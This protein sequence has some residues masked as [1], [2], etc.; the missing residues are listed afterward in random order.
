MRL[1]RFV[2]LVLA[3]VAVAAS[4]VALRTRLTAADAKPKQQS[5][6]CGGGLGNAVGLRELDFPYYSLRDGF[7]STLNLVSAS[8]DPTQLTIAIYSQHGS[9]VLTSATLQPN[10]KLP[11]DLR[12]L[13]TSLGA[14]V[15]GEF[16][17]GS[18]AVYFQGEIMPLTGQVTSTNPVWDRSGRKSDRHGYKQFDLA[19]R[20]EQRV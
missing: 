6:C 14:D 2:R 17:E 9:S 13:L 8:E 12:S 15:E 10:Q 7:S 1:T 11:F 20:D 18:I 4:L 16:G 19:S 3:L 5:R